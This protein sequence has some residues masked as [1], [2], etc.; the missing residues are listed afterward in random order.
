MIPIWIL[1]GNDP[2]R[3]DY[4]V[5]AGAGG[6]GTG[7]GG[8]GGGG[9]YLSGVPGEQSGGPSTVLPQIIYYGGESITITVGAGGSANASGSNSVFGSL[10][11]VGGGRGGY[12]S[13]AAGSGGSGGGA[14][15]VLPTGGA[16]TTN[17]GNEGSN[18]VQSGVNFPVTYIAGAGGGASTAPVLSGDAGYGISSSITGSSVAR[19]GGG[20]GSMGTGLGRG[21]YGRDG[22]GDG[23][24]NDAQGGAS[25]Q[26]TAGTVNTGGGGG[27]GYGSGFNGQ[28]GGSG[29]VVLRYPSFRRDIATVGAG[30]TYSKATVGDYTVYT[31]TAGTD[32]ITF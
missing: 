23:S 4:L 31:F 9:G 18:F 8:G 13:V 3:L 20:G 14:S 26:A 10:D 1:D 25:S 5:I 11:A 12:S 21:G 29:V 15:N 22:G 30:L 27:G 24:R 7:N 28:A 32:T 16:G 19:A 2:F 17:Q 6:G